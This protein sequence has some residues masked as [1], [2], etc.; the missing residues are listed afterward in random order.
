MAPIR[1]KEIVDLYFPGFRLMVPEGKLLIQ[2]LQKYDCK[3]V[4]E[5]G[6][7]Y[8]THLMAQAKL[9]VITLETD[10]EYHRAIWDQWEREEKDCVMPL[11]WNGQE[12]PSWLLERP[13]D[14]LFIDGPKGGKS[15]EIVYQNALQV[16]GI[17]LILCHDMNRS[18][19]KE[20]AEK[21]IASAGWDKVVLSQRLAA[22]T[23]HA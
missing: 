9:F 18:P 6:F 23:K 10:R 11:P 22:F 7:G 2:I 13:F 21:Y 14:A 17:R 15:R 1:T 8:S 5:F 16:T 12:I 4:L 19:D 3:R 20:Y